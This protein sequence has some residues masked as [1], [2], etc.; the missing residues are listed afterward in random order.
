M[1]RWG[2]LPRSA[3]SFAQARAVHLISTGAVSLSP[4]ERLEMDQIVAGHR[5]APVLGLPA[6][7]SADEI[8]SAA[9]ESITRWRTRAGDPLADPTTVEVCEVAIR[10]LERVYADA[11]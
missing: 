2:R 5:G 10:T 7:A 6:S 9:I 3:T 1:S 4:A 11:V 8:R